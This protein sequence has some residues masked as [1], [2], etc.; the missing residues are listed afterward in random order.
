[1]RSDINRRTNHGL[2]QAAP[3]EPAWPAPPGA[4]P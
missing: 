2:D 4:P 3:A 1:L